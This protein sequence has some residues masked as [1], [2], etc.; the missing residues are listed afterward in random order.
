MKCPKTLEKELLAKYAVTDKPVE[1][2]PAARDSAEARALLFGVPTEKSVSQKR[3]DI[4][5]VVSM[6]DLAAKKG[7]GIARVRK[8]AEEH[9][10][11][12]KGS[13]L[14]PAWLE[15]HVTKAEPG[16][17]IALSDEQLAILKKV[18]AE[19]FERRGTKPKELQLQYWA[20]QWGISRS[21]LSRRAKSLGFG[22][23]AACR[24]AWSDKELEALAALAGKCD[25]VGSLQVQLHVRGFERSKDAIYSKLYALGLGLRDEAVAA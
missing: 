3:R 23:K 6:K 7:V 5:K 20:E 8:I 15:A 10:C 4:E 11:Y 25:S 17:K 13:R 12:T 2:R 24:S 1:I 16:R 22:G 18:Y 9:G 21:A 19:G 14:V